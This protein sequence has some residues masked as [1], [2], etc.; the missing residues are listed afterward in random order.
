MVENPDRNSPAGKKK[1]RFPDS[2]PGSGNRAV[3]KTHADIK[4][5]GCM[6]EEAFQRHEAEDRI[7]RPV[8]KKQGTAGSRHQ[9]IKEALTENVPVEN[10]MQKSKIGCQAAE[11]QGKGIDDI[12]SDRRK[13]NCHQD[14]HDQGRGCRRKI[15]PSLGFPERTVVKMKDK[16]NR[17]KD[18]GKER[19]MNGTIG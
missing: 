14:L 6:N 8:R 9:R 12:H 1:D 3:R 4:D 10:R 15:N 17:R 2:V 13:I 19:Q 16:K 18:S 5:D 7:P 11:M